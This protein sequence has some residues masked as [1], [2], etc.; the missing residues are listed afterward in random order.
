MT[1]NKVLMSKEA[2]NDLRNIFSYVS[3][4][5]SKERALTLLENLQESCAKL[6]EFPNRGH[7]PNELKRFSINEYLEI[8]YKPYRIIYEINNHTIY[9]H[10]IINGR[11][12]VESVLRQRLITS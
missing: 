6:E 11:R 9:V 12:D 1:T 7:I 5:D 4:H 2:E 10:C 8:F 3:F